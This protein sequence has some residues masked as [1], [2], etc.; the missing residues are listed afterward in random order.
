MP[1]GPGSTAG[2]SG[3][4]FEVARETLAQL[5]GYASTRLNQERAKPAP[6]AAAIQS[7]QQRRDQWA[8]RYQSLQPDDA[9]GIRSVLDVEAAQLRAWQERCP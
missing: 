9:E 6:N 2:G 1:K 8:S 5:I 4:G 7:W 3:V